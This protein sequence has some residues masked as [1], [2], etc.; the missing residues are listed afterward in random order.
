M[1]MLNASFDL[2]L[3]KESSDN[4]WEIMYRGKWIGI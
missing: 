2:D 4:C 3:G 1:G